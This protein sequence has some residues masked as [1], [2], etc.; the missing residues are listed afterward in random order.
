M[1]LATKSAIFL[2]LLFAVTLCDGGLMDMFFGKR[3]DDHEYEEFE[4]RGS[5]SCDCAGKKGKKKGG[6]VT[7][8]TIPK[9]EFVD[10]PLAKEIPSSDLGS[11]NELKVSGYKKKTEVEDE[12]ASE[13]W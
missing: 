5:C 2:F 8:I 6:G 10:V 3:S 4:K 9:Y 7:A 11:L 12:H 1:G 13:W